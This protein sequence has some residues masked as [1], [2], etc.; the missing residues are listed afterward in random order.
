MTHTRDKISEAQDTMTP[1]VNTWNDEYVASF[2]TRPGIGRILCIGNEHTKA[3]EEQLSEAQYHVG[4][5]SDDLDG[6]SIV[7]AV[8]TFLPDVVYVLL[9]DNLEQTIDVLT[10]LS[11]DQQTSDIPLLTLIPSQ[12][13]APTIEELYSRTGCDFFRL[14]H[15]RIELLA[16]THMLCRL[17]RALHQPHLKRAGQSASSNAAN[18]PT[19]G[20]I[21]LRDPASGLFSASYFFHRLPNEVSRA[22]RYSRSLTLL[23]LRC[24]EAKHSEEVAL[25]LSSTLRRHLR[26][27]DISAR[28]EPDLFMVMLPEVTTAGLAAL[29]TRLSR[30]F[31]RSLVKVAYGRSGLEGNHRSTSPQDLLDRARVAAAQASGEKSDEA[32]GV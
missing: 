13:P 27:T 31:G 23:A 16:R 4:H 10:V 29:E 25:R 14:G 30:D 17:V 24:P 6:E 20:R 2:I 1:S 12:S 18:D 9:E 8:T 21:D 7:R 3:I 5:V 19:T 22:R 11:E 26:D 32:N 15:T 28:I